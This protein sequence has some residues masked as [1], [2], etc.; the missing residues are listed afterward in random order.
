MVIV[1]ACGTISI[2]VFGGSV[3]SIVRTFTY[4]IYSPVQW[5][6]NQVLAEIYVPGHT[7]DLQGS[8]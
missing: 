4:M 1:Y 6:D 2:Q 8:R 3:V 7:G 5:E